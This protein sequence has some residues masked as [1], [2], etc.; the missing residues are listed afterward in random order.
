MEDHRRRDVGLE[1]HGVEYRLRNVG[2]RLHNRCRRTL[3]GVAGCRTGRCGQKGHGGQRHQERSDSLEQRPASLAHRLGVSHSAAAQGTSMVEAPGPASRADP[4][5]NAAFSRP[6]VQGR[7]KGRS[8]PR[9][10]HE[11][12][13]GP[14]S[15][16]P[17]TGRMAPLT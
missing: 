17:L 4:G 5:A 11:A 1:L 13:P 16:T 6:F 9:T 8:E 3:P 14:L 10:A 7:A 15:P 2:D 12:F